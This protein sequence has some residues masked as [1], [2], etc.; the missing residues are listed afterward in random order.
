MISSA[1][2]GQS[3]S[4][5]AATTG[6]DSMSNMQW[7]GPEPSM[8]KR[9][10]VATLESRIYDGKTSNLVWRSTV[11]AVNPSGSD[12]QISRFVSLVVKAL[13]DKKLIPS[14]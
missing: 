12:D 13:R 6:M 10:D 7:F 3:P 9:S 4:P 14:S 11:D 2:Q 1:R 8:G 5:M